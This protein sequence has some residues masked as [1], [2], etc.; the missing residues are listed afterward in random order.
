MVEQELL[1]RN[2][3]SETMSQT[4]SFGCCLGGQVQRIL[5]SHWFRAR[6]SSSCGL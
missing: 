4:Y 5:I 2:R 1:C 6:P 3:T